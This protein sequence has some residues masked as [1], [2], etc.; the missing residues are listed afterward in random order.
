MWMRLKIMLA[1]LLLTM[2]GG[3]ASAEPTP[4]EGVVKSVDPQTDTVVLED[5]SSY[6]A[7]QGVEVDW[8]RPG[9]RVIIYYYTYDGRRTV[10]SYEYV[11]AE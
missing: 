9:A 8:L 10:V 3:A 7:A 5:G 4:I 6:R 1:A 2:A 11:F